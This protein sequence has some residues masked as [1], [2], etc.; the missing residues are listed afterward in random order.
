M[1]D[2]S[3][4]HTYSLPVSPYLAAVVNIRLVSDLQ[5]TCTGMLTNQRTP[6]GLFTNH[7]MNLNLNNAQTS[8]HKG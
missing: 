7:S 4:S 5:V 8:M 3:N 6:F 1:D 2:R